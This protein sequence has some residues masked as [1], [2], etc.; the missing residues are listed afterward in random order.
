[1]VTTLSF[2]IRSFN[3]LAFE[4][5]FF[6]LP[7]LQLSCNQLNGTI[8]QQMGSLKKLSVLA[9]RYNKL[10]GHI[11]ASLGNLQTLKRLYLSFNRFTGTI[12][13]NIANIP[14]L[15][16]LD[17]QNNS[18][19]GFVA[20]GEFSSPVSAFRSVFFSSFKQLL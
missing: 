6:S 1:M 8:P 4:F 13:V 20:P 11:P 17:V 12:P 14:E 9:L 5:L 10:S 16:V 3:N 15:L 18:L 7:V 19:S 2:G